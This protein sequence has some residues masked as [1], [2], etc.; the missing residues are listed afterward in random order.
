MSLVLCCGMP[1][2]LNRV[3][4]TLYFYVCQEC[5]REVVPQTPPPPEEWEQMEFPFEYHPDAN[6]FWI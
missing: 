3:S 5:K 1:P 6:L 2:V 4:P